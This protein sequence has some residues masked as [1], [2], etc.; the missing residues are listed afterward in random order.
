M[1]ED[2]RLTNQM[3]YLRRAK[4]KKAAFHATAANDHEHCEFCWDKFGE[5]ED[6]L[7][8]GY[9]TLDEYRWICNDCFQDF[10]KQFEWTVVEGTEE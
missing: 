5:S 8:S 1:Q 6:C 7:K 2:W 3:N 4:L 10:Q 9:C